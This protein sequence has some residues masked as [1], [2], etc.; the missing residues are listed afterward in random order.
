MAWYSTWSSIIL[1]LQNHTNAAGSPQ[2]TMQTV[3]CKRPPIAYN[4]YRGRNCCTT[5]VA[6]ATNMISGHDYIVLVEQPQNQCQLINIM[7]F[8][9]AAWICCHRGRH[10]CNA[11]IHACLHPTRGL[12]LKAD[13]NFCVRPSGACLRNSG[14]NFSQIFFLIILPSVFPKFLINCSFESASSE[15]IFFCHN[16]LG[17]VV[18]IRI[19]VFR[20]FFLL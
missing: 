20:S 19:K 11:V 13:L 9:L 3:Q 5:H 4:M 16:K 12:C 18:I 14:P 6:N 10:R 17:F 7:H 15:N 1:S 8:L 2:R